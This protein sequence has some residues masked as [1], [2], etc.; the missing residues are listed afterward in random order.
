M[1]SS[2]LSTRRR[3][4]C[5]SPGGPS[6]YELRAVPGRALAP[7]V[8]QVIEQVILEVTVRVEGARPCLDGLVPA[9]LGGFTVEETVP[10]GRGSRASRSFALRAAIP[11]AKSR[12]NVG[13]R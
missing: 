10:P 8:F 1:D 9:D 11:S 3:F 4:V 6:T 7:L 5:V 2:R 13:T 12:R